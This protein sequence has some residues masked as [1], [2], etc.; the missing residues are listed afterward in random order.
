MFASWLSLIV[1][2]SFLECEVRRRSRQQ[3]T[4]MITMAKITIRA[5]V[6]AQKS[7]RP[8][9]MVSAGADTNSSIKVAT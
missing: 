4:Y 2:G 3:R 7:I 9:L 6:R 5:V 8:V 1:V